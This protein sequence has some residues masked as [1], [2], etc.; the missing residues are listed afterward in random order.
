MK[1]KRALLSK[2]PPE[3]TKW[4]IWLWGPTSTLGKG[5]SHIDRRWNASFAN[6][7]VG[8]S[9]HAPSLE[10]ARAIICWSTENF[11]R[12]K[13]LQLVV[14]WT[15]V[16]TAIW[17]RKHTI[18]RGLCRWFTWLNRF[19]VGIGIADTLEG[20]IGNRDVSIALNEVLQYQVP[21]CR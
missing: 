1:T 13:I 21:S 3:L 12:I 8:F 19:G 4:V 10:T 15:A 11:I 14:E 17:F 6:F 20:K 2:L 16:G 9:T 7:F 5:K 18:D